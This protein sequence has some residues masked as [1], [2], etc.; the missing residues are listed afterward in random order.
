MLLIVN[1][2]IALVLAGG[3]LFMLLIPVGICAQT[4]E[5]MDLKD[6]KP[7]VFRCPKCAKEWAP[8]RLLKHVTFDH[9]ERIER[10][11]IPRIADC[12]ECG[13]RGVVSGGMTSMPHAFEFDREMPVQTTVGCSVCGGS[14]RVP[15]PDGDEVRVRK[16][17]SCKHRYTYQCLSCTGKFDSEYRVN[18]HKPKPSKP[19]D[20]TY[21]GVIQMGMA[22]GM[23]GVTA[24]VFGAALYTVI[25]TAMSTYPEYPLKEDMMWALNRLLF[26]GAGVTLLA[27]PGGALF[28][29]VC[30][31]INLPLA[32]FLKRKG[33]PNALVCGT[34]AGTGLLAAA[35]AFFLTGQVP[36]YA[37]DPQGWVTAYGTAAALAATALLLGQGVWALAQRWNL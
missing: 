13:G 29:L 31:V 3:W 11:V 26:K 10:K 16:I 23:A 35:D 4:E 36:V 25:R 33:L 32:R 18:W 15:H 9:K 1:I 27:I 30:G 37:A 22:R 17:R 12:N 14:G 19:H 6:F 5:P 34:V 7:H 28:G 20:S 8:L 24:L 21:D 2:I